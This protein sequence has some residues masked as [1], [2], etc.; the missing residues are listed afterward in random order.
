MPAEKLM[1]FA[2]WVVVGT[3]VAERCPTPRDRQAFRSWRVGGAILKLSRALCIAERIS[4]HDGEAGVVA[5]LVGIADL[6]GDGR[7]SLSFGLWWRR[8]YPS[9]VCRG[10]GP[11]A[12]SMMCTI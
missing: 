12:P 11:A 5:P 2:L 3:T 7:S 8:S 4:A 1:S 9:G 10:P 6:I